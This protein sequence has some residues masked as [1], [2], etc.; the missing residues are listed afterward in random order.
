M[1]PLPRDLGLGF[2]A[3]A[4]SGTFG[5]GGGILLVPIQVLALH[6]EQKRA[7]ATSLVMVSMGA[8]A[9]WMTYALGGQ[10]AWVPAIAIL[11]GGVIGSLVGSAV[12]T[13]SANRVLQAAFGVLM[14]IAAI[15]LLLSASSASDAASSMDLDW[16]IVGY[17]ISGIA[18]GALSALFGIGG[19]IILIPILVTFFGY[20]QQLAAG[21]SIAVMGPIALVGAIRQTKPGLTN[22]RMGLRFGFGAI[23]G[24]IVGAALAL[25]L[26][27]PVLG[28]A[29][30]VVLAVIG[31]R[32]LWQAVRTPSSDRGSA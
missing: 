28:A 20:P 5:V 6:I 30:A 15:R 9:A 29:F 26:S 7:Q 31:L 1:R 23:P 4:F 17:L 2:G 14:V 27:G 18:M 8:F 10:V 11:V 24:A 16:S 19:G 13:R 12:L 32:M 22:W 3:G 21:T 25:W